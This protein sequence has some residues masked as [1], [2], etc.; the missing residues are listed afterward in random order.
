MWKVCIL[1]G[2]LLVLKGESLAAV[3]VLSM[4]S[5]RRLIEECTRIGVFMLD[6]QK[7]TGSDKEIELDQDAVS[8]AMLRRVACLL[9]CF[10]P[11]FTEEDDKTSQ[12]QGT[13][14]QRWV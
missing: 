5:N 13:V 4:K 3:I 2:L 6:W 9:A 12:E 14:R 7:V 11:S 1:L 10:V 8:V